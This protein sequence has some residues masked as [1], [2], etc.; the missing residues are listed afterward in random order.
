MTPQEEL[1]QVIAETAEEKCDLDSNILLDELRAGN[2]LYAE[3]NDGFTETTYY[4]KS[5]V[6]TIPVLF[7]CRNK[8]QKR[9]LDQLEAI[10]NLFQRMKVYPECSTFSWMDTT[11]AKEPAKIG[12]D[13]DGMYHYSCILNNKIYY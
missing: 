7:L 2:S 4:D 13:E 8:S 1:L 5:T 10:C 12:R 3:F 9:C 11:I 6:K